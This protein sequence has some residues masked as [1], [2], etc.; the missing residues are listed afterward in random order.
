MTHIEQRYGPAAEWALVNP[1][2]NIGEAGHESDTGKWKVGDGV[3]AWNDLIYKGGVNTVNG[4][5]G[6]VVLVGSDIPSLAPLASPTFTGSPKAPTRATSDDSANIATTAFVK[7]VLALFI[8]GAPD[9]LDTLDEIANAIANDPN[10]ATTMTTALA[11]KAP[12]ES[13]ALTGNPTA[14]TP[15]TAD[16]DTSVATTAHVKAAI[17]AAAP[18][19]KHITEIKANVAVSTTGEFSWVIP[20]GG[21]PT[22]LLFASAVQAGDPAVFGQVA[23]IRILNSSTKTTVNFKSS[24]AGVALTGVTFFFHAIGN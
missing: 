22:N 16:N 8:D 20:E 24:Y 3:T 21:F 1:V 10:F 4:K 14:P 19:R 12:L 13:P 11:T 17:A 7:Q 23:P 5:F 9:L 18:T 2:L 15:A 6:N